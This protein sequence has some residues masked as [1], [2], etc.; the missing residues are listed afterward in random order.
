VSVDVPPAKLANVG[1]QFV[2][3]MGEQQRADTLIQFGEPLQRWL[4]RWLRERDTNA[5]VRVTCAEL[6]ESDGPRPAY[7]ELHIHANGSASTWLLA[8][9]WWAA[10]FRAPT[11]AD[12]WRWSLGVVPATVI[13]HFV[14]RLRLAATTYHR[15]M[16]WLLAAAA[17]V[18]LPLATLI[19]DINGYVDSF[20]QAIGFNI[21]SR[22]SVL[23]AG[24]LAGAVTGAIVGEN[25]IGDRLISA[26][27][28]GL[29]G[30]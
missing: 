6:A 5:T 30:I 18:M 16:A 13:E 11:Y 15:M 17:I 28:F 24:A 25:S 8:E 4:E 2:H 20:T 19:I 22:R 3:G 29:A 23:T 14:R 9:A 10:S 26:L 27:V 7:A 1:V 12:L 21:L